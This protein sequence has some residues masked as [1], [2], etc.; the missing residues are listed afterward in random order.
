MKKLIPF[1]SLFGLLLLFVSCG[2]DDSDSGPSLEVNNT[3]TI[4]SEVYDISNGAYIDF[5][6]T[7]EV[8]E[9]SFAISDATLTPNT[10]S[11]SFSTSADIVIIFS[12][13]STGSSLAEGTYTE[14]DILNP[15]GNVYFEPNVQVDGSVIAVTGGTIQLEGSAPNFTIA[16]NL[17]LSTG[18]SLTGGYIGTFMD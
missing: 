10:S 14:G 1:L 2:D 13:A 15:E 18:E 3:I 8:Y 6:V 4:G 5:G 16:L 7:E 11:F 9:A 12:L 17:N